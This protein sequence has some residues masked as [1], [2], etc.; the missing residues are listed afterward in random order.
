M[1]LLVDGKWQRDIPARRGDKD[2]RFVRTP[3]RFRNWITPDGAPGPSGKGGFKAEGG[4]YH[5][6]ISHACPWA[7]R[8]LIMR[9]LKGLEDAISLSVTDPIM[10]DEGWFFSDARGA[11]PDTVNN[12]RRLYEVYLLADPECSSRVSVP[13]LWDKETG[14]IVSNESSEIIRMFNSAFGDMASGPDYYPPELRA[15]IDEINDVIFNNVNNGVYKS[16]FA[17]TQEAYAQAVTALFETLDA[18][19]ERLGQARNLAGNR[20]TEADW[21]FFTTLIR[22]DMVYVGHFKCNIR[23]I[24]DYPNLANYLL[25]LYQQPG[26]AETVNFEHF[27]THYY[28]SHESINPLAIVPAGPELDFTVAHDRNRFG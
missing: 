14:T 28:K 22:F 27:K 7:H 17:R 15:Q 20:I 4:R 13:V 5:L 2:G 1:G 21:R 23:R 24:R 3:A 6:Y 9:K 10:D 8:T 18:L 11:F 12:A 16:G 19:D 26:I 25:D